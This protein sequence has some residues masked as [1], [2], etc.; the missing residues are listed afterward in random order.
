MKTVSEFH[1]LSKQ[2]DEFVDT[3]KEKKQ[4][5]IRSHEQYIEELN[6]K[7]QSSLAEERSKRLVLQTTSDDL[8]K[9]AEEIQTQLEDDIDCEIES[10]KTSLS[11]QLE[12]TRDE[13]IKWKGEN[14]IIDKKILIF[15]REISELKDEL[16]VLV[17][18]EKS[19]HQ[20][21]SLLG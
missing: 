6:S 1:E 5:Q 7:F 3:T 13:A 20:D 18:T 2:R 17:D 4:L 14:A 10:S 8:Q 21:I 15:S 16:K 19:F 9:A 12:L 11:N